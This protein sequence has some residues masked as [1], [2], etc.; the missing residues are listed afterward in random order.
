MAATLTLQAVVI[1]LGGYLTLRA[2]R[3]SL[4]DKV[5]ESAAMDNARACETFV[6]VLHTEAAEPFEYGSSEWERVQKHV[7]TFALPEGAQLVVLDDHGRVL[8]HPRLMNTPGLRTLDMAAQ[9]VRL[10]GSDQAVELSR[11]NPG[12]VKTG[13]SESISGKASVAVAYVPDLGV[14]VL[15]YRPQA[16]LSA[17]AA[18]IGGG[19]IVW[20]TASGL[21]LLGVSLVGS[22]VLVR[23]YDSMV[24]RVNAQLEHEVERR[25][26]R[27]L[28][29]R[30]ALVFGLAKLADYRDTDTGAHLERI[31]RYSVVLAQELGEQFPEVDHA[32]IERLRVA[33]SM[34]DI[35]KVGIPDSI[36]L[37]PGRLTEEERKIMETHP[38][39]GADTLLAVRRRVGD[40]DLL[41]MG[42]QV[43]L[44]HH[45]RWDG[46]GYPFR[47]RGEQIPL[48][49]RIVAVADVYDALTSRRVY[50]DAMGHEQAVRIITDGSGTHFDTRVVEAFVRAAEQ[51]NQVRASAI[52]DVPERPRLE[53]VAERARLIQEQSVAMHMAAGHEGPLPFATPERRRHAA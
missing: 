5:G 25:T 21:V 4:A 13:V 20:V 40:D 43:A 22:S 45:E 8:C 9:V 18:R 30:N 53:S 35:G 37:K 51:F 10:D 24:M 29:I 48:A 7:E 32:W 44:S 23:R 38:V 31:C 41:T 42:I 1:G 27:G 12:E 47:L 33:A 17:A 34:H 36:L 2:A 26:R 16:V 28:T 50:K 3:S 19:V 11:V 6:K 49:G 46:T 39:I 52:S 14:K 15:V